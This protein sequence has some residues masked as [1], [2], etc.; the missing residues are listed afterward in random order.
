M[1]TCIGNACVI[2]V[3]LNI[4]TLK[5]GKYS[6]SYCNIPNYTITPCCITPNYTIMPCY[7]TPNYTTPCCMTTNMTNTLLYDLKYTIPCCMT[8]NTQYLVMLLL[9]YQYLYI[10]HRCI[11][12]VQ[13]TSY[14]LLS[15]MPRKYIT[16]ELLSLLAP[17]FGA[18]RSR[19]VHHNMLLLLGT[20]FFD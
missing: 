8:P 13:F 10:V 4:L 19:A 12:S 17:K 20:L 6:V 14:V 18:V 9:L 2:V 1:Y 3:I 16:S 5:Y 7:M 15:P 11:V